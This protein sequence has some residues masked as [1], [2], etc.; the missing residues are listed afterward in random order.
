MNVDLEQFR[1]AVEALERAGRTSEVRDGV[2]HWTLN[3]KH[4]EAQRLFAVLDASIGKVDAP[5]ALPDNP[6][7]P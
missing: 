7:N 6:R 3:A 5:Q 1:P 2:L 4:Y